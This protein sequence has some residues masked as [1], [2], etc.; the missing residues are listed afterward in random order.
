MLDGTCHVNGQTAPNNAGGA[1]STALVPCKPG[2][3]AILEQDFDGTLDRIRVLGSCWLTR[4]QVAAKLRVSRKTL[5]RFMSKYPEAEE[6]YQAGLDEG[7][8][9]LAAA[10]KYAAVHKHDPTMLKW[11]GQH[12]LGQR[13]KKELEHTVTV[14]HEDWLKQLK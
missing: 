8:G 7:D 1:T 11:L 3:E 13:D 2:P 10:Q 9:D 14:R 6:A 12:R 5:W 4:A